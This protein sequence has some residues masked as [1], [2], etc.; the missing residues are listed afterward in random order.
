LI[1]FK[2]PTSILQVYECFFRA[3]LQMLFIDVDK[4]MGVAAG[5]GGVGCTAALASE[6]M[7]LPASS[8]AKGPE[9]LFFQ[10]DHSG[11]DAGCPL[12]GDEFLRFGANQL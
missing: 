9:R 10:E 4:V 6:S 7:R 11:L 12:F 5:S 1:R 8:G 2:K 3:Y